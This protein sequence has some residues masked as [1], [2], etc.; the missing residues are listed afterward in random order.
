M[1]KIARQNLTFVYSATCDYQFSLV[2]VLN[3]CGKLRAFQVANNPMKT[4]G[5]VV[6]KLDL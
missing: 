2:K 1:I 6:M 5:M 4:S 3:R